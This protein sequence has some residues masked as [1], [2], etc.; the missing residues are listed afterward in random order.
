[1]MISQFDEKAFIA[2]FER[3][4][5]ATLGT[6]DFILDE[7]MRYATLDGGKRV[8]PLCVYYGARA[9]SPSVNTDKVI[10]LALAIELI[11]N[12]SLVHDDLPALDNDD[13]RRG[14]LSVHKKFGHANGILI[15]DQLLTQAM[16][17][18]TEGASVYGADFAK[19]GEAI[20]SAAKNMVCGQVRDLNGCTT[21]DEFLKMYSQKTAALIKGAF[22]AG[23]IVAGANALELERMEGFG[24]AVGLAFQLSDDILDNGEDNSVIG[25][26]GIDETRRLLTE[27]TESACGIAQSF[28]NAD[29]L[30]A[31]ARRLSVREK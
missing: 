4:L 13:Y 12:Y 16:C 30:V 31:F 18:L 3:E 5:N 17:V 7:G 9:I 25:I 20:T 19:A 21:K 29:E 15:G 8:R 22:N 23:A 1:M 27:M 11:H 6:S 26:I 10:R 2:E 14:R 28:A 24:E